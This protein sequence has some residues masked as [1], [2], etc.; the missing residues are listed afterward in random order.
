MGH[1]VVLSGSPLPGRW[2]LARRLQER[3]G[4]RRLAADSAAAELGRA[5]VAPG[6]VLVDGDLPRAHERRALLGRAAAVAPLLIEWRCERAEAERAIFHRYA[7]RPR[8]LAEAELRHYEED[9][10]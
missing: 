3:L 2:S 8:C 9:A 10:Q 7:S 1:L 4:A 5:L 6:W